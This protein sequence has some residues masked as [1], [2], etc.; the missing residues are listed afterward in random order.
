MENEDEGEEAGELLEMRGVLRLAVWPMKPWRVRLEEALLQRHPSLA[1][2]G[3]YKCIC[4][5]R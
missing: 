4:K 3:S 5:V 1:L 2:L